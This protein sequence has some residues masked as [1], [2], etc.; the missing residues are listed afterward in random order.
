M[1]TALCPPYAASFRGTDETL[2]LPL[3]FLAFFAVRSFWKYIGVCHDP[4]GGRPGIMRVSGDHT[5][6]GKFCLE[7]PATKAVHDLE[8]VWAAM[9]VILTQRWVILPHRT[10]RYSRGC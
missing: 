9:R 3:A 10:F 6:E 8:L 4:G 5:Y 2:E 7:F 1:A